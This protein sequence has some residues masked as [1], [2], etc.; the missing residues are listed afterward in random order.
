MNAISA[1]DTGMAAADESR[2]IEALS[3]LDSVEKGIIL[4]ALQA[5]NTGR[6]TVTEATAWGE[7][8]LAEYRAHKASNPLRVA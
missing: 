6:M 1:N 8:Q 5:M 4:S 3:K 7:C 2:W